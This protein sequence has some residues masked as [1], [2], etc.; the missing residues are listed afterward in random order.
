MKF[1]NSKMIRTPV[2]FYSFTKWLPLIYSFNHYAKQQWQQLYHV[3]LA[4]AVNRDKMV[5]MNVRANR[6]QF[7]AMA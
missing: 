1:L 2:Y 3:L 5:I 7:F 6:Q 4:C